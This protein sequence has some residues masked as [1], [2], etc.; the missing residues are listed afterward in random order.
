MRNIFLSKT[1]N[2]QNKIKSISSSASAG[3]SLIELIVVVAII[4]VL[5]AIGIPQYSKFKEK[6]YSAEAKAVLGALYTAEQSFFIE[7]G[8]YHSSFDAIGF[9]PAARGVYNVGFGDPGTPVGPAQGY[10]TNVDTTLINS[11]M[12]CTGFGTAPAGSACSLIYSAPD[13]PAAVSVGTNYFYAAAV[14]TPSNYAKNDLSEHPILNIA[15]NAISTLQANAAAVQV[16]SETPIDAWSIDHLKVI[17]HNLT[18]HQDCPA[19]TTGFPSCGGAPVIEVRDAN[20]CL[21]GWVCDAT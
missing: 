9:T 5:G 7:W 16:N 10:T 20:Q 2:R 15:L 19:I 14:S 21:T 6:A 3:F 17:K 12:A 18:W 4:G 1:F 13:L 8:G 11:K